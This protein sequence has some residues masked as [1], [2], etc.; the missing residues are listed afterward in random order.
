[1]RR[2]DPA[3]VSTTR[4]DWWWPG[5]VLLALVSTQP[6]AAQEL[7]PL[8]PQ[9]Q[10]NDYPYGE[11]F[12]PAARTDPA[13][14]VAVAWVSGPTLDPGET[15][16]IRA[17]LLDSSAQPTSP[18]FVVNQFPPAVQNPILLRPG[19]DRS[20]AVVVIV[21]E[22]EGSLGTDGDQRSI[23]GR[24]FDE[25]GQPLGDQF[26][27]NTE[28][29]GDQFGPR[30]A[31]AA[32]GQTFL[33]TWASASSNGRSIRGQVFSVS[34]LRIGPEQ[35]YDPDLDRVVL[36]LNHAALPGGGWVVTWVTT[37]ALPEVT[38]Y[39]EGIDARIV[40]A[41]GTPGNL[42]W[43]DEY[44]GTPPSDCGWPAV[45]VLPSG[46]FTIVWEVRALWWGEGPETHARRF[47]AAGVPLT[48]EIRIS[49]DGPP[50]GPSPTGDVWSFLGTAAPL[51]ENNGF[52]IGY[53]SDFPLGDPTFGVQARSVNVRGEPITYP[54][55]LNTLVANE[56]LHTNIVRLGP[57]RYA[58][59]WESDGSV[60]IDNLGRSI[61]GRVFVV[62]ALFEDGFESGG[63]EGWSTSSP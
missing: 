60:G 13:G 34:G 8:G 16:D 1:M 37:R 2:T 7:V 42:I 28:F 49:H 18:E 14:N 55:Q 41:D 38:S 45:A 57:R 35:D 5:L 59:F 44:L 63:L 31:F 56:Q 12:N 53:N 11:Q 46:E 39:G 29:Q 15:V 61:Q 48:P 50:A 19:V 27:V 4:G 54:I 51:P 58:S 40:A 62:D 47:S 9:F 43:V 52:V 33:V 20:G 22:S 36:L 3:P 26:Q 30:V 23:Q 21:W 24:L 6:A 32:D 25:Q 10:V 17:R